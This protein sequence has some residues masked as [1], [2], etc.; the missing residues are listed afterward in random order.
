MFEVLFIQNLYSDLFGPFLLPHLKRQGYIK[1]QSAVEVVWKP[2][3]TTK[4]KEKFFRLDIWEKEESVKTILK[5][6][7]SMI[8][9]LDI[10]LV[11]SN[12]WE[13][14]KKCSWS[15][16]FESSNF[17]LTSD[18]YSI[19]VKFHSQLYGKG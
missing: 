14:N 8:S 12:E 16:L 6:I 4:W 5:Y 17:D 9:W 7:H 1:S 10:T 19:P 15:G 3:S 11:N 2:K 18:S 13:H